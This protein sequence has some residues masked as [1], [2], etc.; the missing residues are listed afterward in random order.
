[1]D[2]ETGKEKYTPLT[3]SSN[4]LLKKYIGLFIFI[5]VLI[6]S[7][8]GL[9]ISEAVIF[10]EG[11]NYPSGDCGIFPT[12]ITSFSPK[13]DLTSLWKWTYNFS[14]NNKKGKIQR[15][16]PSLKN[17]DT[18]IFYDGHLV[19]R[20]MGEILSTVSKTHIRDCHGNV[21]YV[22]RTGNLFDTIINGNKIYVSYELRDK[23]EKNILGYVSGTNLINNDIKITSSKTGETVAKLYRNKFSLVW[24]WD[25]D[26]IDPDDEAANPI[27]LSALAGQVSFGENNS[28]K[29]HSDNDTCNTYFYVVA[30][31][32]LGIGIL[33]PV[34]IYLYFKK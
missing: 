34:S 4:L 2:I 23:S 5:I 13:K 26:I 8:I 20:S 31:I 18:N 21:I 33:I 9:G 25:I 15:V 1:M 24:N 22:V 19:A 27:A 16:C 30:Y 14:I 29:K 17:E 32:F 3:I 10:S 11:T 6:L 12:N 7:I 28:G